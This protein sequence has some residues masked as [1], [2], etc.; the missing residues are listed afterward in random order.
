[1]KVEKTTTAFDCAYRQKILDHITFHDFGLE[2]CSFDHIRT[3]LN[4]TAEVLPDG[5]IHQVCID[6][7]YE[8]TR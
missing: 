3:A 8:I 2:E 6:N 5:H 7:G 1:M 4:V